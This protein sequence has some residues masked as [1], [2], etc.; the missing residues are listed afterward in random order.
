MKTK[1]YFINLSSILP[2]ALS[3][4][5]ASCRRGLLVQTLALA[6]VLLVLPGAAIAAT[7]PDRD[8]YQN[9]P[10]AVSGVTIPEVLLVVSK[11]LKMFQQGY[12]ALVDLDGDGR[13]DTGFNPAIEYVGYFDSNSC[14]AY[15]GSLNKGLN[16]QYMTG[17]VNGYF[18]RMGPTVED[19]TDTQIRASRPSNLKNYVVSPRSPYGVCYNPNNSTWVYN[20]SS[21]T[22]SGNWLNF[23]A[24][25]RMDA[26]RKILYGG[27]RSVDTT[28]RTVLEH[29]FVPPD[30]TAWGTEVRSDDTWM[31]VTPLSAYYDVRKYTPFDKPTSKKA[32][33]IGRASDFG[34]SNYYFPALRVLLNA[35]KS[36]I[37]I[38]GKDYVGKTI[39]ATDPYGRYWDWILGNRPLPDDMVLKSTARQSI[40]VYNLH[41]EVCRPQN[42]GPGE[43][44]QTFPGNTAATTDDT[45]KPSGLL[46]RYG[47]GSSLMYFGLLT[48]NFG[49]SNLFKGGTVRNHIGPIMGPAPTSTTPVNDFVAAVNEKT[50]Q[51]LNKG[52]IK[53]LDNLMIAGRNRNLNP[54]ES[55]DTQKY[56]NT[57]SWSNPLGEMFYEGVRYLAGADNPTAS[58]VKDPDTDVPTSTNSF[59]TALRS[60]NKPWKA[61][62]PDIVTSNCVKPIILLIS[63]VSTDYDGDDV[64]TDI[65]RPLLQGT[66]L[67][68]GLTAANLPETF[69]MTTYLNTISSLEGLNSSGQAKY[70]YSNGV[71]DTCMPKE[72]TSLND[73]K[74]ICPQGQSFE[75]TY[76]VVAAA[77]YAHIRDFNLSSEASRL[78]TGVDTFAVTMSLAFPELKFP[79]LDTNNQI[80]RQITILPVNN[81]TKV[82]NKMMGFLN[83][84]VLEWDTDRKGQP[85]HVKIKVNFS[86]FDKGDDWEGDGQVT[87]EI[88][89][90]TDD[91]TPVAMRDTKQAYLESGELRSQTYYVFKNPSSADNTSD[92]ID[93]KPS[94][95]KALRIWSSWTADGTD[96]GLGMGYTISGTT[97][98]GTYLDLTMNNPKVSSNLTPKDCPYV[99]GPTS[100]DYG[101]G[102]QIPNLKSQAR[103]F[104]FRSADSDVKTLPTT[105]WLAAKYGGFNDL[106]HNGVPDPGEWER[107]DG[108]PKNLFM[109]DKLAE[110][111]EQMEKAFMSISRSISTGTATSAS[112]N[113]I[114]GGGISVHTAYYP[115]YINPDNEAER[116]AWVGTVYGLFTDKWGNLREDSDGNHRLNLSTKD[117]DGDYILTF[118]SVKNPPAPGDEPLCYIEGVPISRCADEYGTNNPIPLTGQNGKPANI[119]K[120]KTVWD[121]GRWLAEL[122]SNPL[123]PKLLTGSR[124]FLAK[125]STAQGQR[126]I[127][128]TDPAKPVSLSLFNT[129]AASMAVLSNYLLHGNY[130]EYLPTPTGTQPT[131]SAISTKLVEYI[132]GAEVP[133]WRN[134]SISNPWGASPSRIVW[135]MGDVINSKPIVVGAPSFNFDTLYGSSSYSQ[136]KTDYG[137]RRQMAYFGSNDGMLHAVNI[138]FYGSLSEGIIGYNPLGPSKQIQHELGSEIWAYIPSSVLPHLKWQAAPDYS[139]SYLVDLKPLIA[140]VKINNQWRTLLIGGLRLGGRPIE[141][142]ANS[143]KPFF[144][145]IFCLDITD[146]EKPPEFMWRYSTEELGL[147]V[148]LP[149]VVSSMGQ[150]YVV[151]PS[152]PKTD[153]IA[154]NG[155]IV[156]G[157]NSPF[158]GYSNQKARLIVIDPE[159]GSVYNTGDSLIVPDSDSNSF[160]TDPFVPAAIDTDRTDDRWNNHVIYYGLTISRQ[161]GSCLD[162]GA[163]YRLRMVDKSTFLP[164]PPNQW[165]LERFFSPDRPVTGAVNATYDRYG[166]MWV[167]FATGRLWGQQDLAP[168]SATTNLQACTVNHEQY[169]YGVREELD[170]N[171]GRMLFTDRTG[172]AQKLVDLTG[173]EV[174]SDGSV[175]G[176]T[177]GTKTYSAVVQ[178]INQP[179]V[180]GYRRRLDIGRL[181]LPSSDHNFEMSFTQP[182]IVGFGNG[183]SLV[184]FTSFEP[185]KAASFCGELGSS[186]M[187]LLDTFTGLPSP[188]LREVFAKEDLKQNANGATLVTGGISTGNELN[189]EVTTQV[190]SESVV[191]GTN[192]ADNSHYNLIVP[193][194]AA[195]AN[196]VISWREAI[197]TGFTMS[198]ESMTKELDPAPAP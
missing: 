7:Q 13:V 167:V 18:Y 162:R 125:A 61:N 172:A 72:L 170:P 144:S 190:G 50:G 97:R 102:K 36:S 128:F 4:I 20:G 56:L 126:L 46:Q 24:T 14:Y 153:A 1:S 152:G 63:D 159:N 138:G 29:S 151:I 196:A 22:F 133:G 135:R 148:G 54:V 177:D 95:V 173:V 104:A 113:S 76:S 8:K 89:L 130:Q 121:A 168:C 147:S 169:L 98:D 166:N 155:S 30:S 185:K 52:L 62:R 150:W 106:N 38:G 40:T 2:A 129:S 141:N 108:S 74:G 191:F 45:Y 16:G 123:A 80:E 42:S 79:V 120:I 81:S 184:S 11:D 156:Y 66:S 115:K 10:F 182:K 59:L 139:H 183:Q 91:S 157:K 137:T 176:L 198:P 68:N 186:F 60:G 158:D 58:Y 57:K 37:N 134:R 192:S 187:Y 75:G 136:F 140:D 33:F 77:Y 122:D 3:L 112:V 94:Q 48:G 146:P 73:V 6:L 163:V 154:A 171:S 178:K 93:I 69:S 25:S 31:E 165:K 43:G 84:M 96:K 9:Q 197:N 92:F 71:Q 28:T 145:E 82:A 35:D 90:L 87:Y 188:D 117:G 85:F 34:R 174:W 51:I 105:M 64:G 160:F 175:S 193:T 70:I 132:Q 26:I 49:D 27:H 15:Y 143:S 86:D 142:P 100:G 17:D 32:H 127:Y 88:D 12:P 164:L 5:S 124:P 99:G 181:L 107:P 21:R 118:N 109:A 101:C 119:H 114:L 39:Y 131:K 194:N 111:P 44:C 23:I 65:N 161:D 19:Q 149:S 179:D 55:F 195:S 67:P 41:V 110:L 103:V 53:N 83:Y 116:L 180:P 189:T 47:G 78:Q